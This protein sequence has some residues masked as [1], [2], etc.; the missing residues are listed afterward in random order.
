MLLTDKQMDSQANTAEDLTLF[1]R[2]GNKLKTLADTTC[3]PHGC[4]SSR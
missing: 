3:E 2:P 4:L 1:C